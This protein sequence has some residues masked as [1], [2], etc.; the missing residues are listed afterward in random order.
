LARQ[1]QG[2]CD[3]HIQAASL[4][5]ISKEFRQGHSVFV[6]CPQLTMHETK[7]NQSPSMWQVLDKYTEIFKEP[8]QLLPKRKIDHNIPLKEG[9]ELVIVRP[10]RYAYFQKAEIEKQVQEMLNFG[11]IRPSTSP[12]SSPV[13]LVKK[14]NSSWRFCIDYRSLNAVTIKDRFPIS[15]WKI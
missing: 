14:K 7:K 3:Q 9:I 1:L 5:E 2:F 13:L 12:F 11:L 8:T 15:T 6:I 10:Y 4:K